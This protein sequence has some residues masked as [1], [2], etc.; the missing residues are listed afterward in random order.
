LRLSAILFHEPDRL[1]EGHSTA[2]RAM[3]HTQSLQG[4]S[5]QSS[6][7]RTRYLV[8][9]DERQQQAIEDWVRRPCPVRS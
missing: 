9:A 6:R 1:M 7:V 3:V 4:A 5:M 2:L 8:A